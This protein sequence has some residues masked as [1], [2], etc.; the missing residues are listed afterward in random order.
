MDWI[1][2][3]QLPSEIKPAFQELKVIKHLNDAGFRKKFGFTCLCVVSNHLC[4]LVPAEKLVSSARK[5]TGRGLSRKDAG[6]R[7]LN[8]GGYAWR[9]FL[10]RMS[11]ETVH[12][13]ER[14]TSDRRDDRIICKDKYEPL[15]GS[16]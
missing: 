3:D 9:R 10:T 7:F 16:Q 4:T 6:Y 1:C 13:M 2:D 8:H 11:L 14:L 5:P 15:N 12:R